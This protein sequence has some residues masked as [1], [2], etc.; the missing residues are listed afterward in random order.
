VPIP[1]NTPLATV[2]AMLPNAVVAY[3]AGA[4]GHA[5]NASYNAFIA[6]RN[7][8]LATNG[9]LAGWIIAGSAAISING[10]LNAY[11][12]N[13][14]N[15]VLVPLP[16]LQA[17]LA[18]LTAD[19]VNWIQGVSLPVAA[20]PAVMINPGTGASLAAEL[21]MIY[22]ALSAPGAITVSGGFVAS[23]KAMHCLF[24]DLIPMI[25]GAHTG[26]S[27]YNILRNTYLPPLG[28]A[29]W[30]AWLGWPMNGTRNPSPRGAGRHSWGADQ[31]L[32][33]VGVNQH[34][35]EAWNVN[36]GTPGLPGFLALDGTL[37]TTGIPRIVDKGLW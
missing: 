11:G 24:P 17:T 35:Y 33:A 34:I 13:A 21:S 28:L 15:S 18:A 2:A 20:P 10:L 23:S 30:M 27:Y 31:L 5:Y 8:G 16:A 14:R 19:S 3:N 26:L 6:A 29:G 25:D 22:S 9:N 36:N 32:A 7:A 37:G 12:M 1:P 4:N